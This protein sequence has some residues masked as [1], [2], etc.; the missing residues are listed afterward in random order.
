MNV[1][2][3]LINIL[4]LYYFKFLFNADSGLIISR[5]KANSI[6]LMKFINVLKMDMKFCFAC[7]TA[8]HKCS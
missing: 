1:H 3:I 2:V 4:F 7:I 6:I 5:S 8:F